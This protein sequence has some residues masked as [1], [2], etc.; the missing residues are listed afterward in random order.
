VIAEPRDLV[1]AIAAD[2][3]LRG[4][5]IRSSGPGYVEVG[6]TIGSTV[7]TWPE[8]WRDRGRLEPHLRRARAGYAPLVLVGTDDDF[9]EGHA[10]VLLSE[11]EVSAMAIPVGAERLAIH[12]HNLAEL[13]RLRRSAADGEMLS[14]RHESEIDEIN[15]IGR[16]LSSQ[17]NIDK[18]LALIL[19]KCRYVTNADAGSVY[20]VEGDDEDVR[21]RTLRF[22]VS[23]NDSVRLDFSEFTLPVDPSS[24]VGRCVISREVIN[25]PDLY[26]LDPPGTG[27]N[28]WG[29][30]H[31]RAFDDKTRY[32]TRSMLAVP[33][34][35]AGGQVIGVVQLINRK[36][37]LEHSLVGPGEFDTRVVPF[38][39]R[40][41]RLAETLASQAGI[42][43]E[44]TLLYEDI[45]QL[46][47]GFVT[48]AVTAIEQRDPTTSGHSQRV[49]D[50]TVELAKMTERE[51]TGPYASYRAN[52][53]EL[54]QIEYAALLHDFGK[55]GVREHVLVKAKKLYESDRDM[56]L[57]RFDYI[58]RDLES[59][60]ERLKVDA[61]LKMPRDQAMRELERLDQVYRGR[62]RELDAFIEFVLQVNEPSLLGDEGVVRLGDIAH[63]TYRDPRGAE[64]PY[65]RPAEVE[66]LQIRR[67]SLTAPERLEI[68]SHVTH[69]YNF[70]RRIPWG[71]SFKSVPEYAGSHHEKLDG[72]GYPR[73]L[74]AEAIST[75][76]RMMTISDIYDALTAKDRPYKPAVP[77]TRALD[78]L[79]DEVQRGK[80]DSDLFRIFVDAKVWQLTI[81]R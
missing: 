60:G 43:L 2:R 42:S 15:A 44:N 80:V 38:D 36:R 30:R 67:G 16:A 20:V 66:K 79:A 59:E 11:G 17:R 57:M 46:F 76:T 21:Q 56:V 52:H 1:E 49:A 14:D 78:I 13:C 34:I 24:I 9:R 72:T 18:L 73:G 71:R 74:N 6:L 25:I 26:K 53:E 75:P 28:P 37:G 70:L 77:P 31:N 41:Q 63:K 39:P 62:V 8:L 81:P 65:L 35:D 12:L 22:K 58:R 5:D 19:E 50:L 55:V 61:L 29:F 27:N 23:Q 51:A 7:F 64:L 33:M 69:T 68:E 4:H 47:E 45:R 10:D 54:K 32:Q 40:S 3:R 48:A